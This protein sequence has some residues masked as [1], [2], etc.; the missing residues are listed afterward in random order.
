MRLQSF[1]DIQPWKAGRQWRWTWTVEAGWPSQCSGSKT[2]TRSQPVGTEMGKNLILIQ[3]IISLQAL[4]QNIW[5]CVPTSLNPHP[6]HTFQK[7]NQNW[8]FDP[9]VGTGCEVTWMTVLSPLALW[10]A[11]SGLRTRQTRRI[12]RTETAPALKFNWNQPWK[13][14]S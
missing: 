14:F 11:R 3:K 1:R 5:Y 10:I 4:P 12:F 13:R 2:L 9:P 6:T 8:I 7:H